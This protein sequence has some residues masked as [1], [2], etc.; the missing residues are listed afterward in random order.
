MA[1]R[2][3]PS[4]CIALDRGTRIYLEGRKVVRAENA[5]RLTLGGK[6][7]TWPEKSEKEETSS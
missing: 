7:V 3:T 1:E 6:L 4:P 2:Y 5:R